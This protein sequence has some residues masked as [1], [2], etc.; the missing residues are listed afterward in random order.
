[1]RQYGYIL[2]GIEPTHIMDGLLNHVYIRNNAN[3]LGKVRLQ[4]QPVFYLAHGS[5]TVNCSV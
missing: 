3:I 4:T 1:M 5:I 2:L